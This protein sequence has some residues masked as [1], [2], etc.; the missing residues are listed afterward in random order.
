MAMDARL[1]PIV[2]ALDE[3]RSTEADTARRSEWSFFDGVSFR[4][5]ETAARLSSVDLNGN[6]RANVADAVRLSK[7]YG[8]LPLRC[9][10]PLLA[11]AM[12]MEGP[13]ED[14][15]RPVLAATE[16]NGAAGGAKDCALKL[17]RRSPNCR[18]T[19]SLCSIRS[20]PC[21]YSRE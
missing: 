10:R 4:L 19:W 5:G 20:T 9:S 2:A 11:V 15:Q 12:R 17:M 7:A 6:E 8:A 13:E 1:D 18:N 14:V 21:A 3:D 16:A